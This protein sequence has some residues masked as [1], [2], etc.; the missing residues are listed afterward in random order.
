[1]YK[2]LPILI[3]ILVSIILISG[4][5]PTKTV[6]IKSN[7]EGAKVVV[8]QIS[9][10]NTPLKT[11]IEF[12]K[13]QNAT[14]ILNK[15][16]F[17]PLNSE[18]S[19]LPKEKIEY[20]YNLEKKETKEVEL[21]EFRPLQTTL[22][23]RLQ[24]LKTISIAY[25]ETIENSTAVKTCT[26]VT[27]VQDPLVQVGH[28]CVSPKGDAIVFYIYE[29]E[30]ENPLNGYSNL[31]RMPIGSAS[32]TKLSFG[33]KLDL[34]PAYS[35]DGIDIYFSS[36]RITDN[37]TIWRVKA[38]GGGGLTAITNGSSEDI[39][40]SPFADGQSIGYTSLLNGTTEP[41]IWTI[42]KTG[43][44]PTQLREGESG[45]TS[46]SDDKIAFIRANR[47]ITTI[48]QLLNKDTV[49]YNPLQIWTI[50]RDGG[51]E[52]QLTQNT[53]FNCVDPKWS[54]N[55]EYLAYA[56]DKGKDAMGR[57]NFDI[58]MIKSDGT[59]ETQLTTN[60]SWDDN[61]CW[62]PDGTKIYFRSNRGGT[63]NLWYF[64]LNKE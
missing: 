27:N 26:R 1:M 63:W 44:L 62:S 49:A 38:A 59:Q 52:T 32:Q 8:N 47:N 53:D 9:V 56:S 20:I 61:P 48:K 64:E 3:A 14:I 55:G 51:E 46:F 5:T 41:Q 25:I 33:N 24:K 15:D 39:M 13:K 45:S 7:P 58:W 6:T 42:Q 40:P 28:P 54:P 36:N 34:F 31:Y 2:K 43:T 12:P 37:P 23:I 57:N 30:K 4:C 11:K 18:I 50:T 10:G 19:L 29:F 60:G 16:E 21:I 35:P 17:K 22:G